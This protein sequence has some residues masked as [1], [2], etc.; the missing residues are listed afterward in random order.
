LRHSRPIIWNLRLDDDLVRSLQRTSESK[1]QKAVPHQSLDKDRHTRV[2]AARSRCETA[3]RRTLAQSFGALCGRRTEPSKGDRE[4]VKIGNDLAA[5]LRFERDVAG[6]SGGKR[7]RGSA[8]L[9]SRSAQGRT[10]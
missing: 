1:F 6:E 4:A 9:L 2:L 10:P 5:G 7:G 8:S 3:E